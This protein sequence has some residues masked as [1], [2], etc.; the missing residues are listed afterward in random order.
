M[1]IDRGACQRDLRYDTLGRL[2]NWMK[3][4][5]GIKTGGILHKGLTGVKVKGPRDVSP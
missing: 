3:A 5:S 2:T 4:H 1:Q